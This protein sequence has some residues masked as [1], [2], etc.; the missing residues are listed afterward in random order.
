MARLEYEPGQK[1]GFNLQRGT[2][3][4]GMGGNRRTVLPVCACLGGLATNKIP[5]AGGI[6]KFPFCLL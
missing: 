5:K 1:E 3:F 2:P 6:T 4:S